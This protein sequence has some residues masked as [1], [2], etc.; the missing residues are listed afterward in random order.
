MCQKVL[1]LAAQLFPDAACSAVLQVEYVGA[2]S[3][4]NVIG[5]TVPTLKPITC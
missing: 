3:F 2:G 4:H 5:F 1:I